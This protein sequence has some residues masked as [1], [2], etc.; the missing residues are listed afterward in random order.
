MQSPVLCAVEVPKSVLQNYHMLMAR[1][2]IVP[3]ENTDG[4]CDIG[5]SGGHHVHKASDHR[6]VYRRIAGFFVGLP[7]VKLHWQLRGKWSGLVHSE[8]HQDR[9]NV[10]VLMDVD[11]VM[12]PIAFNAHA[13]IEGDTPKTMRPERVLHQILDLLNQALVSN[14]RRSLMYRMPVPQTMS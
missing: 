5:P 13:E 9:P 1:V 4:I 6:L 12:L 8:R 14:V 2:T 7:L 3:A 10:D 11:R